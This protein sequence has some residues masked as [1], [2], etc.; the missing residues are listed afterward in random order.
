[1]RG[2]AGARGFTARVRIGV[3]P[4]DF[5]AGEVLLINATSLG[6][7]GR[8]PLPIAG[9]RLFI[10]PVDP[11]HS[12][13]AKLFPGLPVMFD[14]AVRGAMYALGDQDIIEP[15]LMPRFL[16]KSR[17]IGI[18][19]GVKVEIEILDLDGHPAK[20][21]SMINGDPIEDEIGHIAIEGLSVS[22][23]V[24]AGPGSANFVRLGVNPPSHN[25]PPIVRAPIDAMANGGIALC[26][27][28]IQCVNLFSMM[29]RG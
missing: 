9:G 24:L 7:I 20:I 6:S 21:A 23:P 11:N 15:G 22:I 1:M 17:M 27:S 19:P 14:S 13:L 12:G 16:D 18:T 29:A 3:R 4:N 2:M 26:S 28:V 25:I 5:V 10:V 8:M